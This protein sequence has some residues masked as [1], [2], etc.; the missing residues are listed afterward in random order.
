[1]TN[2]VSNEGVVA[3]DTAGVGTARIL[4]PLLATELIKLSLVMVVGY[5]TST[6]GTNQVSNTGVVLGDTSRV[7]T[8]T[9]HCVRL[10]AMEAI[11]LFL[12]LGTRRAS[13]VAP[14]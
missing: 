10:L 6:A 11:K 3:T 4:F 12:D 7:G 13:V 1:M 8:A 5:Y 9:T 14:L 2:K